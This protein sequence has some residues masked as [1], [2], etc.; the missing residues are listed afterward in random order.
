MNTENVQKQKTYVSKGN[1]L[2]LTL[3]PKER[4]E[5]EDS[6]GTLKRYRGQ[7]IVK[8][9][10]GLYTT[11]NP[12]EIELLD[13]HPYKGNYFDEAGGAIK[14]SN[15]PSPSLRGAQT[16]ES[17]TIKEEKQNKVV[18]PL[19]GLPE[20]SLKKLSAEELTA[21]AKSLKPETYFPED[22]VKDDIIKVIKSA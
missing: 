1:S 3:I 20:Q 9:R 8:F 15:A 17:V 10:Q 7:T 11:S 2:S 16:T 12:K 13:N 21:I 14:K 6:Q 18:N 4:E 5:I 22:V 19:A